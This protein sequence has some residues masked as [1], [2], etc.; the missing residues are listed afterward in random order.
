MTEQEYILEIY[1][2]FVAYFDLNILAQ[3]K[4]KVK[5]TEVQAVKPQ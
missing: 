3:V 1:F 5:I 2:W 4:T